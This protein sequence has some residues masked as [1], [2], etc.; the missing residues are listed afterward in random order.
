MTLTA[1]I[2]KFAKKRAKEF[3]SLLDAD[4]TLDAAEAEIAGQRISFKFNVERRAAWKLYVELNTRI[5]TQTLDN[6]DGFLREAL[7]SLHAVFDITR[8]I[9][10]EAGPEVAQ[11]NESLGFYAM[12]ILNQ[13]IRPVLVKW[14]P[15]LS[16]WE[17]Q[18]ERNV[19]PIEH[20]QKWAQA[21]ALRKD[22]E[23]TRKSLLKYCEA[24]SILAGVST[25][26][27]GA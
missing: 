11:G 20:E 21:K 1:E 19:S 5:T 14:H 8:G 16:H 24:L 17:E 13:V 12:E 3:K 9:L 10:K 23:A 18:R 2:K 6:S 22:L 25:K 4:L 15:T 26:P 27:K 7:T